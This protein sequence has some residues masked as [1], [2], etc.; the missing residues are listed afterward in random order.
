M[1]RE[2]SR[3]QGLSS[4]P[5]LSLRREMTKEAEKRDPGNDVVLEAQDRSQ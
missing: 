1:S 5:H 2:Q 4:L 3:S